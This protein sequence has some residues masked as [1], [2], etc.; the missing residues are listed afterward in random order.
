[1]TITVKHSPLIKLK[2]CSGEMKISTGTTVGALLKALGVAEKQQ[3]YLVV[4]VNGGKQG[5]SYMIQD[6]DALQLFLPIGGG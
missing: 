4:T 6:N 2:G 5:L 3:K 1:M